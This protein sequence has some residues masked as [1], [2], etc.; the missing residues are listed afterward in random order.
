MDKWQALNKKLGEKD[1]LFI[2]HLVSVDDP[3]QVFMTIC[4]GTQDLAFFLLHY[5]RSLY[6]FAGAEEL[7]AGNRMIW[8]YNDILNLPKK[9]KSC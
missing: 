5:N 2:V 1:V 6:E 7:C 3:E 4:T 8:D 9:E